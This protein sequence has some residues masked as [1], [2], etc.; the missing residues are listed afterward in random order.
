MLLTKTK[1]KWISDFLKYLTKG[2]IKIWNG[3]FVLIANRKYFRLKKM[4]FVMVL[5]SSAKAGTA[6]RSSRWKYLKNKIII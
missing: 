1:K 2:K 3:L 4:L 5:R 6:G